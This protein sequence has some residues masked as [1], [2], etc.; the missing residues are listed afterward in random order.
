[1]EEWIQLI[2]DY[3]GQDVENF[4]KTNIPTYGVSSLFL[5]LDK[6]NELYHT[7]GTSPWSDVKY[8]SIY[9][10]LKE[11]NPE[12]EFFE[13]I[14]SKVPESGI[15]VILPVF[16]GSMN[17]IK[18]E[19]NLYLWV[20]RMKVAKRDYIISAKLDGISA[21]FIF[22]DNKC[23]L[24]TRGNG[25]IGQDISYLIKYINFPKSISKNINGAMIRGE[26][27][28]SRHN[29]KQHFA[30]DYAN[31]RNF[32][33]GLVNRNFDKANITNYKYLDFVS[34]SVYKPSDMNMA[35]QLMYCE[36]FG[37]NTTWWKRE[38]DLNPQNLN[39]ILDN[40]KQDY[41]YEIDGIIISENSK[42]YPDYYT[43]NIKENPK[44][45]FAWKNPEIVEKTDAMVVDV[46]WNA[47]KDKYL[48]PKIQITETVCEGSKI[49]YVSGFNA[50]FIKDNCIGKGTI[51]SIGLSGGVIPHI[52]AVKGKSIDGEPCMPSI[53][54]V[55]TEFE[56]NENGVDLVLKNET[57]D[58]I[59][60]KI[61]LFFKTLKVDVLKE[62]TVAILMDD[63]ERPLNSIVDILNLTMEEWCSYPKIGE[64]KAASIIQSIQKSFN[65]SNLV[66]FMYASQCFDRNLGRKKL[67]IILKNI[68][69][70]S[71][72]LFVSLWN[73]GKI[74]GEYNKYYKNI[75]CGKIHGI[76][77]KI[78]ELF[79]EKIIEFNNFMVSINCG[80]QK[81]NKMYN[82]PS[83][84]DLYK[85]HLI[86]FNKEKG[87]KTNVVGNIVLSGFRDNPKISL[88][89]RIKKL[90]LEINDGNINNET[91]YVIVKSEDDLVGTVSS[92]VKKAQL[93]S[94]P[95]MSLNSFT[96]N[97]LEA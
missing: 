74:T 97:C 59:Q 81:G 33:A 30:D 38:K 61:C 80:I 21:L 8:D 95:V 24:Y 79:L 52:F 72:P 12:H 94:I 66:D 16:L 31:S 47:S 44:H 17:K 69:E 34:Y 49:N 65:N 93:K 60:K 37:F 27:I 50:K 62:G 83:L 76:S 90:N 11:T 55:G 32:V 15:K 35:D 54:K 45:S 96:L 78:G 87:E 46:I 77:S 51:V 64:K 14:G 57:K 13:K 63:E 88:K 6:V 2:T 56:W 82:L 71:K 26:I 68:A 73:N 22:D 41:N 18:D 4:V 25:T 36:T 28:I 91:K 43:K 29:F 92:K 7:T 86:K 3:S 84:D 67:E 89:E 42:A 19:K 58:V 70:H 10:Y 9:D 53:E 5:S 1:M 85:K 75:V 23:K 20:K 48:K 39:K 40:L